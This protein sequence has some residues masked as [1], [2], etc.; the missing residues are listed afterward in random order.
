MAG[1]VS[2][3]TGGIPLAGQPD[4]DAVSVFEGAMASALEALRRAIAASPE[5][6]VQAR[7]DPDFDSLRRNH[8]FR[9]L[10]ADAPAHPGTQRGT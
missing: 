8:L 4:L 9:R 2:A 10:T 1:V 6:R 3:L 7:H 5:A